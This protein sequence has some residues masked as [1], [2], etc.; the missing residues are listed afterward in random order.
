MRDRKTNRCHCGG[1]VYV[2]YTVCDYILHNFSL[3]MSVRQNKQSDND[4]FGL[5]RHLLTLAGQC[6]ETDHAALLHSTVCYN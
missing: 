3:L 1:Y 5:F 4:A 2:L 6:I